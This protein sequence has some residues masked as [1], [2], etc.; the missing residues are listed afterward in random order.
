MKLEEDGAYS[1][2]THRKSDWIV[3]VHWYTFI[4][5]KRNRIGVRLYT[6]GFAQ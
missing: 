6:R 3:F 2:M 4:P 5:P 1:D